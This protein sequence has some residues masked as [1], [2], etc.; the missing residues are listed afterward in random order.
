[1]WAIETAAQDEIV[2]WSTLWNGNMVLGSSEVQ[3]QGQM[4]G[5]ATFQS[6][7]LGLHS[8]TAQRL[9]TS[10]DEH[11]QSAEHSRFAYKSLE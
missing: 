11:M 8:C 1:M 9:E 4:S 6:L 2:S 10:N 7:I 3:G 5:E